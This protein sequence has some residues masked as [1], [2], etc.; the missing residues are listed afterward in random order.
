MAEDLKPYERTGY[1]AFL[2]AMST[3]AVVV[4]IAIVTVVLLIA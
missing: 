4:A 3:L 2:I 1:Q